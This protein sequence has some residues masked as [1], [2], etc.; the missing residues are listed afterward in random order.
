[1]EEIFSKERISMATANVI[2]VSGLKIEEVNENSVKIKGTNGVRLS[3]TDVDDT[4]TTKIVA[5]KTADYIL[6]DR[7]LFT[8]NRASV[9][10]FGSAGD[11]DA[12]FYDKYSAVKTINA[13]AANSAI[14]LTGNDNANELIAGNSGSTLDGGEGN[15]TLT[16]GKGADL[17]IWQSGN[18]VIKKFTASTDTLRIDDDSVSDA[19]INGSNVILKI[20]NNTL[21]VEGMGKKELSF[22]D[23]DGEKIF[24]DSIFYDS[25]KTSATLASS[26][27]KTGKVKLNATTID[28]SAVKNG[29]NLVANGSVDNSILGGAKNDTLD[30]GNGADTI[31]GG[32]GA[33]KLYGKAG[34]DVL[35]GGKGNDSLWGGDGADTFVY[36]SGDGKDVIFGFGSDD[37]LTLDDIEFTSA[38]VNSRGK[39][40]ALKLGSGSVTFKSFDADTQF[41]IGDDTYQIAAAGKNK[42]TFDKVSAE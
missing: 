7:A 9:S 39:E 28:A 34:D 14:A 10:L 8:G 29:V 24:K 38:T 13:A 15:D 3:I 31:E 21:T 27:A 25:D 20:G 37:L 6:E 2:K 12:T 1:M 19:S 41:H 42:Y 4:D 35:I 40:V 36:A 11:F 30:G 22:T 17:F 33:D 23:Y 16:G 5:G 26:F 18:D 32:N